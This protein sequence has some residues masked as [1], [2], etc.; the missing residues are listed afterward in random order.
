[1]PAFSGGGNLFG[2]VLN[3]TLNEILRKIEEFIKNP[4]RQKLDF[5]Y[6]R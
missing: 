2:N 6:S 5:V 1:M 4:L 3:G